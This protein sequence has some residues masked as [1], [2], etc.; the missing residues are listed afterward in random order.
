MWSGSWVG[1]PDSLQGFPSAAAHQPQAPHR[2]DDTAQEAPTHDGDDSALALQDQ[3]FMQGGEEQATMRK[4]PSVTIPSRHGRS[5]DEYTL[6]EHRSALRTPA[7]VHLPS[8]ED[9]SFLPTSVSHVPPLSPIGCDESKSAN[10][11]GDGDGDGNVNGG[12]GMGMVTDRSFS[13]DLAEYFSAASPS[14]PPSSSSVALLSPILIHDASSSILMASIL[15]TQTSF[16]AADAPLTSPPTSH[17]HVPPPYNT[18]TQPCSTNDVGEV[19]MRPDSSRSSCSSSCSSSTSSS[20]LRTLYQA[21]V[22][23]S[24]CACEDSA[25][26]S[27]SDPA[28]RCHRCS[29]HF[30]STFPSIRF[31]SS[32]AHASN[33]CIRQDALLRR[34]PIVVRKIVRQYMIKLTRRYGL[35]VVAFV[36]VCVGVEWSEMRWIYSILCG[37]A[38]MA[39]FVQ[40]WLMRSRIGTELD[41]APP[42]CSFTFFKHRGLIAR[43]RQQSVAKMYALAHSKHVHVNGRRGTPILATTPCTPMLTPVDHHASSYCSTPT[44]PLTPASNS[45][46]IFFQPA[47]GYCGHATLNNVLASMPLRCPPPSGVA[48]PMHDTAAAESASSMLHGRF[49]VTMPPIIHPFSLPQMLLYVRGLVASSPILEYN[50]ESVEALYGWRKKEVEDSKRRIEQRTDD[51]NGPATTTSFPSPHNSSTDTPLSLAA[52]AVAPYETPASSVNQ[53]RFPSPC[54]SISSLLPSNASEDEIDSFIN[55]CIGYESFLLLLRRHTNDPQ[56]RLM[57]NFLRT[58]LFFCEEDPRTMLDV[59]SNSSSGDGADKRAW[60]MSG[61]SSPSNVSILRKLFGGHWSPI[62]AYLDAETVRSVMQ[63]QAANGQRLQM[64]RCSVRRSRSGMTSSTVMIPTTPSVPSATANNSSNPALRW[65]GMRQRHSPAGTYHTSTP[66]VDASSSSNHAMPPLTRSTSTPPTLMSATA[67]ATATPATS[68]PPTPGARSTPT[69]IPTFPAHA[70]LSQCLLHHPLESAWL[71]E[72]LVLIG[73]VNPSY[74]YYLVPPRR[75]F[76]AIDTT[77]IADGTPR[78]IIRIKIKS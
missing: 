68:R 66:C 24:F 20:S 44:T 42:L 53:Y 54:S 36:V 35:F 9:L 56:Y 41:P 40:L 46:D 77:S 52:C 62:L 4:R 28:R 10:G 75:L 65:T 76:G 59:N 43:G 78:G 5:L 19:G 23:P 51:N 30:Q 47:E 38:L 13:P 21:T 48:P 50:I 16:D 27:I 60:A 69:P 64:R 70:H 11:H 26:P 14:P 63:E 25:P 67:T 33:G 39:L 61:A 58:P 74:G 72:G 29:S 12:M 34:D 6:E 7:S 22:S 37:L 31:T 1:M 57:A 8:H 55:R 3:E 49:F 32:Y 17:A 71:S 18:T 73:D 2:H 15:P 45:I